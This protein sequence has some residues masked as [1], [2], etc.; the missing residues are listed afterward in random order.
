MITY[1][2]TVKTAMMQAVADK[3]DAATTAGY[4][5]LYSAAQPAAGAAI[6]DQIL[7]ADIE[8]AKPCGTVASG[9]LTLDCPV[10]DDNV[11]A[12]GTLIWGRLYDGDSNWIA[13]GDV[14]L[15]GSGAMIELN[16]VTSY[17]GGI[18]RITAAVLGLN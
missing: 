10:A 1:S 17:Q 15:E 5:L 11:P 13:D 3:L 6:T 4:L 2:I 18:V 9:V 14:G 12:S 16:S 8:L 7:L